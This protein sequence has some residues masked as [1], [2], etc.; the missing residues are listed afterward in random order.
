MKI[1]TRERRGV[2]TLVS[3]DQMPFERFKEILG[4]IRESLTDEEFLLVEGFTHRG[5]SRIHSRDSHLKP[6]SP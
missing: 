1:P 6:R 4:A 5:M 2:F 3:F